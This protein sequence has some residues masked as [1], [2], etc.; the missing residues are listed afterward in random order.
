MMRTVVGGT[1]SQ[2]GRMMGS[3]GVPGAM[4][5][6]LGVYGG[7]LVLDISNEATLVVRSVGDD[8]DPAVRECHPVLTGYNSILVLDLL[9][10][11]ICS[12]ITIL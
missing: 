1:V 10:G 12:R 8:L 2:R 5:W 6:A 9:L 4:G 11:K 3:G 7:P